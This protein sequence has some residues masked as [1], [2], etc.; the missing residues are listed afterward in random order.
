M[1][2]SPWRLSA[3]A[4]LPAALFI[5]AGLAAPDSV[6]MATLIPCADAKSMADMLRKFGEQ[7]LARAV[8]AGNAPLVLQL[9]PE[10]GTFTVLRREPNGLICILAAGR[11]FKLTGKLIAGRD[12]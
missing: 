5:S 2:L 4:A 11:D 7:Q 3:W 10:T 8:D 9:N 6:R 12:I 1:K